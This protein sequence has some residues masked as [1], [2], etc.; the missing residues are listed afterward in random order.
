MK[1]KL[2]VNLGLGVLT[3]VAFVQFSK[4]VIEAVKERQVEHIE[5][6]EIVEES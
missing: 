3:G 1:K 6:V 4:S 5:E 2:I